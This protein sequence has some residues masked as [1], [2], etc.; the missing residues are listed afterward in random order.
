[1]DEL[2]VAGIE[3]VHMKGMQEDGR[4]D[5]VISEA[6]LHQVV[7]NANLITDCVTR[8]AFVFWYLCA[9]PAFREGNSR[10]ALA[11]ADQVLATGGFQMNGSDEEITGLADSIVAG[12]MEHEDVEDWLSGHLRKISRP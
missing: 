5:R 11:V 7:F 3:S 9:F 6:N 4:D 1:M 12:D 2:T 10:T 8:A